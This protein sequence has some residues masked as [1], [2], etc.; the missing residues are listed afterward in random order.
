MSNQAPPFQSP[1]SLRKQRRGRSAIGAMLGALL[2][3]TLLW[4]SI[5]GTAPSPVSANMKPIISPISDQTIDEDKVLGPLAFTVS[6]TELLNSLVF[7]FQSTNTDLAPI[8]RIVVGGSG[9]NRTLTITPAE[10][11]SGTSFITVIASDGRDTGNV[12]FL[13]TVNNVDDPPTISSLS[14]QQV[15][16]GKTTGPLPVVVNDV[17]TPLSQLTLGAVATDSDLLP[18]NAFVYGG[19]SGART[20]EIRPPAEVEGSTAVTLTVSDGNSSAFTVFTVNVLAPNQRPYLAPIE[21]QVTDEDQA[22]VVNFLASDP[23]TPIAQLKFLALSSNQTLAPNTNLVLSGNGINRVLT[24]TPKED[25]YG[26]TLITISVDDGEYI[27][28]QTF[29]LTVNPVND[30]P[31]IS[32]IPSQTLNE[33]TSLEVPFTIGDV[34]TPLDQ[35]ALTINS[36]NPDLLPVSRIVLKRNG[37]NGVLTLTP[38]ADQSGTTV[39]IVSVSDGQSIATDSFQVTVLPV[40]DLPRVVPF[41]NQSTLE[42]TVFGPFAFIVQDVESP[43]SSLVVTATSSNTNL[44]TNAN[45]LITMGSSDAARTMIIT[46]TADAFGVTTIT[47]YVSDGEGI[48]AFQFRLTV[49]GVNDRPT[50][51]DIDDVTTPEDTPATVIFTASDIETPRTQL[52]YKAASSN[53]ALLPPGNAQFSTT[54]TENRLTLKPAPNL[55]GAAII[56]VTVSD[57]KLDAS[58]AFL[59]TVT[60]VNDPPT[61]SAI[62]DLSTAEGTDA[63]VNV[64][65]SDPDNDINTLIFSFASSNP[66]LLLPANIKISGEG[67]NRLLTLTPSPGNFGKTT[68]TVTVSDG[69]ESA[70]VSFTLTVSARPTISAIPD[71]TVLEDESVAVSFTIDDRDTALDKLT[72]SADSADTVLI[73]KKNLALSGIGNTRVLTITP[74]PDLWGATQITVT[75]SD[76]VLKTSI[77]FK[78]TVIS[79]DDA[80]EIDLIPDQII[81][82]DG[83]LSLVFK[84]RDR[85]TPVAQI[86]VTSD[87]TNRTLIPLSGVQMSGANADRTLTIRPAAGQSGESIIT[88]HASD[89]VNQSSAS[90]T[91]MVN[92][93]PSIGPIANVTLL[94]DTTRTVNFTVSDPDNDPG[95]L[96]VTAI[97]ANP[98]LI[99]STGLTLTKEGAGRTLTITPER[100]QAGLTVITLTVSDGRIARQRAFSVTVTPVNDPPTISPIPDQIIDEDTSNGPVPFTIGDVDTDLSKLTLYGSSSNT[101]LAPHANIVFGGDGADRTVT[102]TPLPDL[103]GSAQISV[104]VNDGNLITTA[105]YTLTV[106]PVN[107]APT[108]A[109]IPPQ[110]TLEDQSITI[111]V[112]V[113][114]IDT[115]P[116]LLTLSAQSTNPALVSDAG[117]AF[118]GSGKKRFLTITPEPDQS[119][120][121]ALMI[122]VSD[123]SLTRST[124]FTLTVINVN[125]A[126]SIDPIGDQVM[127]ED[128][129][130]SIPVRLHDLDTTADLLRLNMTSSDA[131]L[132]PLSRITVVGSGYERELILEPTHN[133][134]GVA[135]IELSVS[136]GE[137][138]ASRSFLVT[139]HP[140]NDPPTAV[141]DAY[142]IITMPETSFGVLANDFD[143]D[144]DPL[145][146]IAVSQG[147]VGVVAI[148]RDNTI[149]F[150]IPPNFTGQDVF[151]YTI[152][153]GRGLEDWATVTVNVVEPPGPN[154]PEIFKVDP[155]VGLND[156]WVEIIITGINFEAGATAQIGPYPLSNI[157]IED[158]QTLIATAPAFLPPG[159]Y[160]VIVTNVDGRAAVRTGAY[161]VDTDKIALIS[162]RPNRGQYEQPVQINVYGL[163]FDPKA[164]ALIGEKALETDFLN[165]THLRAVV[166]P[167]FAKPGRHAMTVLNP[168]GQKYTAADAYTVY[169][170]DSD[171]LFAYDYEL[172]TSPT[173]MH[174]GQSVQ[175]GLHV[176]RQIGIDVLMDVEVDFY[177][178]V[179]Y[180]EETYIGRALAPLL[181]P[182]DDSN[183]TDV[184]WTPP[185][186][187][188]FTLYAVLD[189]RNKVVESDETNNLIKRNV[190][191]MPTIVD[192]DAPIIEKLTVNDGA[193]TTQ[194]TAISVTVAA[195]DA[196]H[197]VR[198][199]YLVE[200]EYVRGADEWVPAQWSGWLDY[201][202]TPTRYAWDLLPSPGIKYLQ[203]WAADEKG[204]AMSQPALTGINYVPADEDQVERGQVRLYRYSLG[205][206]DRL[207]AF[208]IPVEGDPDLYVWPP[209]FQIRPPWITNLSKG[210][211]EIGFIAPMD[212]VYQLEISAYT[213]ARYRSAVELQSLV[214]RVNAADKSNLDP[215]KL[216]RAEPYIPVFDMPAEEYRLP[217]S[218]SPR[219]LPVPE[220]EAQRLLYLPSLYA[221][222]FRQTT[223]AGDV[224]TDPVQIFLPLTI[225]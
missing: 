149:R 139:V 42:D 6:G 110:E 30:P 83:Q 4:A 55:F 82:Q 105:T 186:A 49:E 154:T 65:V 25:R 89:G 87:S 127:D 3:T 60:P 175:V 90:F 52:T 100:D 213:D 113:D 11:K 210:V 168:D 109:P 147:R 78:L 10:E 28:S 97:A 158:A 141:D 204:N 135:R 124:T 98:Q 174:M 50:I 156:R 58:T 31:T 176:R 76:G 143:V 15:Q 17:D 195:T 169:T 23:D 192:M 206:G 57:G 38:T 121:V 178:N 172:W 93:A 212:G 126:P 84:V 67:N 7:Y 75:V 86:V 44:V 170:E 165:S 221:Q 189:P 163:N 1:F 51:S 53:P 46:P 18:A 203:A 73:P 190:T 47:L 160:D 184:M 12:T 152:S 114:D 197:T 34:D 166:P 134:Y 115:L 56:T 151:T 19:N 43:A 180:A 185:H 167:G 162:V 224:E 125:D 159:R 220:P 150:K 48:G 71:Q 68:V 101:A 74:A 171:D 201:D 182:G 207:S 29:K 111:T 137:F 20:L 61:L 155:P 40:N 188:S 26:E 16:A 187:G 36:T 218:P 72:V 62:A 79:V 116:D 14:N 173:T 13:L 177:V 39:V 123:G 99:A 133:R 145:N 117:I 208:L 128:S 80:P 66:T 91:V 106:R 107:D 27:S 2:G 136:D 129:V 200:Y 215:F 5:T 194:S 225:R 24:I 157:R 191:V 179:P 119:G 140:V 85:D 122:T 223:A 198:A 35:L 164:V 219:P 96:T 202:G 94:E 9:G 108:I 37:A 118:S 153:D 181:L 81:D 22:L 132:L 142:T 8:T 193:V 183:S 64:T 92:G 104:T 222:I 120:V 214:S 209:D 77:P 131:R 130:L 41:E 148:N 70:S 21:D 32:D 144:R 138:S 211:D 33:D 146:V 102:V 69:A 196:E 112:T 88:L 59:L 95:M 103:N 45:I 63:F 216:R 161:Q 54:A 199:I 205:R 217:S